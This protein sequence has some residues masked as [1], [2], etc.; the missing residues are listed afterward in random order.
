MLVLPCW[1]MHEHHLTC[2]ARIIV[3][4]SLEK[5]DMYVFHLN[6]LKCNCSVTFR[7]MRELRRRNG[8]LRMSMRE[9]DGRLWRE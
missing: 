8:V 5:K 2:C 7:L 1:L 4:A 6:A 3:A 9:Q